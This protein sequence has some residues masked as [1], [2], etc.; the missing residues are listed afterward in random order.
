MIT[1][2]NTVA[3]TWW[4]WVSA[5]FWQVGLL[6]I[7]IACIDRLIRRWAWP[8]LRYALWSLVLIK[9]I[10]PPTL[11]LPSGIVPA[12]QPVANQ[13][14][15]AMETEEGIANCGLPMADSTLSASRYT[16][17]PMP[18]LTIGSHV[19]VDASSQPLPLVEQSPPETSLAA[20]TP[21]NPSSEIHHPQLSWAFYA[22]AIWL[23]GTLT[24]GLWLLLRLNVLAGRRANFV[25]AASLPQSFYDRMAGCAK[26]LGLRR[27]PRVVVVKKLATPAVFGIFRPVLLMPQGYL[28]R[29]TRQDTEHMLLHE[30]AHIKRGDLHMHALYMLVQI[31][32]WYNPLLWL[33]RRQLHHLRELSCDATVA[34]L[35]RER[36]IAYRQTLLETA[37]RLLATSAEPGLGLLGLFEDS[38]RLAVRLHWLEKPTWRYRTMKSVIALALAAIMLACVLPMAQGQDAPP[39]TVEKVTP[40]QTK[41]DQSAELEELKVKLEKLERERLELQ[42]Q[43]A[44]VAQAREAAAQADVSASQ[45]K[46]EAAKVKDEIAKARDR[47]AKARDEAFKARAKAQAKWAPQT[48]TY[49]VQPGDTLA[50]IAEKFYGADAAGQDKNIARI[51]E[52]NKLDNTDELRVGQELTIPPSHEQIMHWDSAQAL[53]HEQWAQQMQGWA[54][55]VQQ[56]QQSPE[57]QNWQKTVEQWK[58]SDEFIQWEKDMKQWKPRQSGRDAFALPSDVP[59]M[60]AMP[61]M[62]AMP[63]SPDGVAVVALPTPSPAP[64]PTPHVK[65]PHAVVADGDRVVDVTLPEHMSLTQLLDLAG[66]HIHLDFIYDPETVSGDITLKLNRTLRGQVK[67]KDLYSLLESALQ[68]KGLAMM[69]RE[70]HV[71]A[72]VPADKAAKVES[73]LV[74]PATPAPISHVDMPHPVVPVEEAPSAVPMLVEEPPVLPAP[75]DGKWIEAKV[76]GEYVV[77]SLRV[78]KTFM[79]NNQV[80]SITVMAG[81][82]SNASVKTTV[83]AKGA[84]KEEAEEIARKVGVRITP[85]ADGDVILDVQLPQDVDNQRRGKI[86]V[87][88]EV[89]VPAHVLVRVRQKVGNIRLVGLSSKTEAMTDVGN[90]RAE[91]LRGYEVVLRTN[92]GSIDMVIPDEVSAD[93]AAATEIGAIKSDFDLNIT[94]A[95]V[96]QAGH[97]HTALGSSA[98]GVVGDENSLT[99][100]FVKLEANVGSIRIRSAE[101]AK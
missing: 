82:G 22:M 74:V 100:L 92:V 90:I 59:A 26:R 61:E 80:G 27:I 84:S 20:V 51:V 10:L 44:A 57:M 93:I 8:H 47:A 62:P 52:A 41:T 86:Q 99:R 37:R 88:F 32:Y 98:A 48:K 15:H 40:S 5:M 14:L 97:V 77:K 29:L 66:K 53:D 43:L 25:A 64:A 39:V 46:M 19:E 78:N 17:V 23:A 85:K 94:G 49:T 71:V 45:A 11:S 50:V 63:S 68:F 34:E 13:A 1:T 60:P 81:E 56:W 75:E 16:P 12:L 42:Q 72:I 31:V 3:H 2:L 69:P 70:G 30:L 28:R 65:V 6:I 21:A 67:V 36:T 55:Q 9:L 18:P 87:A 33:V 76:E 7:L 24:L 73:A 35:L 54:E 89:V 91:N 4:A 101:R 38:N 96:V 95:E 79:I 83:T 58:N